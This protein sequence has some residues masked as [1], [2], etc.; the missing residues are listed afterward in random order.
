MVS[1]LGARLELMRSVLSWRP[2]AMV[3]VVVDIVVGVVFEK[4]RV[5][6]FDVEP[7]VG[8]LFAWSLL[9]ALAAAGGLSVD[10]CARRKEVWVGGER[11]SR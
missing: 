6:N 3:E 11:K 8:C 5:G 4:G 7:V 9:R 1:G 10:S 2:R